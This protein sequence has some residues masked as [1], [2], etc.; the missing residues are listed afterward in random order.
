MAWNDPKSWNTGDLLTARELNENLRDNL[1]FLA[2]LLAISET[3]PSSPREGAIWIDTTI[4]GSPVMKAWDGDSWNALASFSGGAPGDGTVTTAKL[5]NLAVTGA[6]VADATLGVAKFSATGT[7]DGTN[8][9]RDDNSWAKF[10]PALTTRGPIVA[11]STTLPTTIANADAFD[12]TDR[13]TV[14]N[15]APTGITNDTGSDNSS[16]IVARSVAA[17]LSAQALGWWIEALV[18]DVVTDRAFMPFGPGSDGTID[19]YIYFSDTQ[20]VQIYYRNPISGTNPNDA[21]DR[22]HIERAHNSAN[23][24]PSNSQVRIRLAG[25]YL[26]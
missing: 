18:S 4:A 13:W 25:L 2:G 16:L 12:A 7:K 15:T 9:L 11:T 6:K 10:S 1:L 14:A 26:A 3:A 20:P 17:N 24:L 19:T 5:A 22:F 23:T 8:F 21:R